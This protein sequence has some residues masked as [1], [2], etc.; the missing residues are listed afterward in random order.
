[1]VRRFRRLVIN[2]E[3]L[4]IL[5]FGTLATIRS[6]TSAW[7]LICTS[8]ALQKSLTKSTRTELIIINRDI[9][10]SHAG[11]VISENLASVPLTSCFAKHS[12]RSNEACTYGSTR[13]KA[14]IFENQ[15]MLYMKNLFAVLS[16]I[17][18]KVTSII[19]SGCCRQHER[20][21][22]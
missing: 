21:P 15:F 14:I 17:L 16:M 1:M 10:I 12:L 13:T 11:T 8:Q 19:H 7:L 4:L 6:G 5:D 9:I 22:F 3:Y 2:S 18:M 20:G